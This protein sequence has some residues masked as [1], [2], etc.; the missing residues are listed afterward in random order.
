MI[1][2]VEDT[3]CLI[4]GSDYCSVE[5]TGKDY[6]YDSV[7]NVFTFVKCLN[8]GHLYLQPRPKA[9][10]AEVIYPENYSSYTAKF[11][12][13]RWG[14]NHIKSAV[15]GFRM[16]S[17]FSIIKDGADVLELGCGD[18]QLLLDMKARFQKARFAGLDRKFSPYVRKQLEKNDIII[19]EQMLED[20][21]LEDEHYDLIILN[22]LLEHLWEP[23]ECIKKIYNALKPDGLIAIETPNADGYDRRLFRKHLWGAYYWP[24]HL[25]I[26]SR[27]NLIRF[28]ED[29]NFSV[30]K[31]VKLTA[32][33]TW[34]Y[35][36][37]SLIKT[38]R[39]VPMKGIQNFFS[40]INPLALGFFFVI[41]IICKSLGLTTSNQKIIAKKKS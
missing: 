35:S 24:R 21:R 39:W 12:T 2:E 7:E 16:R 13:A 33:P 8:C 15:I 19:I 25:N 6:L 40:D 30:Q 31:H 17:L 26:F 18:G 14:I 28:L 1:I 10:A 29:N 41:D 27:S 32:P 36:I 3:V 11:S 5:A 9:S 22:Q 37:K 4:C 38:N 20:A 23:R 34:T